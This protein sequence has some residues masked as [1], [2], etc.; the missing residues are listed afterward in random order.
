MS[1]SLSSSSPREKGLEEHIGLLAKNVIKSQ[2][3]GSAASVMVILL[4]RL[5]PSSLGVAFERGGQKMIMTSL[6]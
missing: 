6:C 1:K 5:L 4:L 3:P 2:C